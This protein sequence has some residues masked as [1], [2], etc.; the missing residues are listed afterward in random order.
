LGTACSPGSK[1]ASFSGLALFA[2]KIQS[3]AWSQVTYE[4]PAG[5]TR[6]PGG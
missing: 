2:K 1:K 4:V 5:Q 3:N 6:L